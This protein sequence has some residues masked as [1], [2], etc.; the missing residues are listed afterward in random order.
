MDQIQLAKYERRLTF[1]A[2][3]RANYIYYNNDYYYLLVY[4]KKPLQKHRIKINSQ[5][6][7][8]KYNMQDN[9]KLKHFSIVNQNLLSL[10]S[11]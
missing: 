1:K 4:K 7:K 2:I 8:Y 10:S 11:E 5:E 9:E 3:A 6:Y